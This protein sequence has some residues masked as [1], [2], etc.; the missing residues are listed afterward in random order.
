M[1]E[2]LSKLIEHFQPDIRE[3]LSMLS[4]LHTIKSDVDSLC[5]KLMSLIERYAGI[6]LG[7]R[8]RQLKTSKILFPSQKRYFILTSPKIWIS[9]LD[10]ILCSFRSIKFFPHALFTLN[11]WLETG[12]HGEEY[13][14]HVKMWQN[15]CWSLSS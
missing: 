3:I 1:N 13:W 15:R 7:V 10:F 14:D 5:F 6:V 2:I 4:Y 9:L 11:L 12:K 8:N